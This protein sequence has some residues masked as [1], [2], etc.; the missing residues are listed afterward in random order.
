MNCYN[1]LQAHKT[2]IQKLFNEFELFSTNNQ[3]SIDLLKPND[4]FAR[5]KIEDQPNCEL[6]LL[7]SISHI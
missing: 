3:K 2:D 5:M 7:M 4:D 6:R 1:E